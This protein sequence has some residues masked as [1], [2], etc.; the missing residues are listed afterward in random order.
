M[1]DSD[2]DF[3]AATPWW[4]GA[5]TN[6][7]MQPSWMNDPPPEQTDSNTSNTYSAPKNST[8]AEPAE[9]GNCCVVTLITIARLMN[10]CAA[11]LVVI[12][13][14]GSWIPTAR[15]PFPSGGFWDYPE[16][17]G[18]TD[19]CIC[20]Q[21]FIFSFV[22]TMFELSMLLQRRVGCCHPHTNCRIYTDN[23]LYAM[24]AMSVAL[25]TFR[26][27]GFMMHRHMSLLFI[28][29]FAF[30]ACTMNW[31]GVILGGVLFANT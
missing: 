11:L 26:W 30:L 2:N 21:A 3:K 19:V 22:V 29:I 31:F 17:G 20:A 8:T 4:Q 9:Q 12:L 24:Q 5:T 7:S 16:P 6:N 18:I 15:I 13:V 28:T 23:K 1:S 14:L 25:F 10:I 27:F